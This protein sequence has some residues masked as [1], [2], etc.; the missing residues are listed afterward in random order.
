MISFSLEKTLKSGPRPFSLQVEYTLS[1]GTYLGISG[2]SGAGKSTLLR[3][4]AGLSKPDSGFLKH[5]GAAWYDSTRRIF[6]PPRRRAVGL[7]FQEPSL[8][9]HWTVRQNLLYAHRDEARAAELLELTRMLPWADHFPHEL[10]G[11]QSQRAALARALMRSPQLL[12]LDEPFSAL[13]ED[14]RKD[15]GADLARIQ[16]ETGVTAVLVTHSRWEIER[17]CTEVL[18]LDDG[19]IV[20]TMLGVN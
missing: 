11:G 14:L 18:T 15:L 2:R 9:P 8:F 13:D 1:R 10:S 12:L 7:V 19:K 6:S 4:L 17:Y 20:P 3:L 5:G 16:K